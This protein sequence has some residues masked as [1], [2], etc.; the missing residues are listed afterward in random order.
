MRNIVY[1]PESIAVA[2]WAEVVPG[3]G[4][5]TVEDLEAWPEDG[6]QYEL[7]GGVLIRMPFSGFE[8]S[9]IAA[10]F[11]ARLVIYVE[12]HDLG[13][14]TGADGGFRPDPVHP[15]ETELAPDV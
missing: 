6:W 10:R 5:M 3:V 15:R 12:E 7:V 14:V 8:A 9:S 11:L 1:Q 2:P 4:P 13:A